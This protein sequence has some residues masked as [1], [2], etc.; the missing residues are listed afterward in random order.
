MNVSTVDRAFNQI[1]LT[2]RDLLV[3]V[4]ISLKGLLP[5]KT[6]ILLKLLYSISLWLIYFYNHNLISK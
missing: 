2:D 3:V 5:L 4:L 1:Q 6:H